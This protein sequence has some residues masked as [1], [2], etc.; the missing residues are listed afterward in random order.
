M[1][2]HPSNNP[3]PRETFDELMSSMNEYNRSDRVQACGI[4]GSI[5][6]RSN[7]RIQ[8]QEQVK[9]PTQSSIAADQ[10]R[11]FSSEIN[12]ESRSQKSTKIAKLL[13]RGRKTSA[14]GIADDQ[15][16]PH[17]KQ[18]WD[19]TVYRVIS[20]S[21]A[22]DKLD[23]FSSSI[24]MVECERSIARLQREL[25]LA[26]QKSV[27]RP[28]MKIEASCNGRDI[29]S[30]ASRLATSF[31]VP[32]LRLPSC[33]PSLTEKTYPADQKKWTSE[34]CAASITSA[35]DVSISKGIP[36]HSGI[37]ALLTKL[38]MAINFRELVKL[39]HHELVSASESD[40]VQVHFINP[41]LNLS[42]LDTDAFQR[43]FDLWS[44]NYPE[45][46][47]PNM[48]SQQAARQCITIRIN[49]DPIKGS[50][51]YIPIT[52]PSNGASSMWK[53]F[54]V[55]DLFRGNEKHWTQA[56]ESRVKFIIE[57]CS[58]MLMQ[59]YKAIRMDYEKRHA[60][61]MSEATKTLHSQ[62]KPDALC[63]QAAMFAC[64]LTN[65]QAARVLLAS[66]NGKT[67]IVF[68]PTSG[69]QKNQTVLSDEAVK[70]VEGDLPSVF[71][72]VIKTAK[73]I[74]VADTRRDARFASVTAGIADHKCGKMRPISGSVVVRPSLAQPFSARPN[75]APDRTVPEHSRPSP[76][77]AHPDTGIKFAANGLLPQP[78]ASGSAATGDGGA[79]RSA[80]YRGVGAQVTHSRLPRHTGLVYS[81]GQEKASEAAEV[82]EED[83]L[84]EITSGAQSEPVGPTD[85][86]GWDVPPNVIL[87]PVMDD[88][89]QEESGRGE[90][91]REVSV[92][93][94][95]E[96]INKRSGP[97]EESDHAELTALCG[98][99]YRCLVNVGKMEV[100][101]DSLAC[102]CRL[103]A[104]S[105]VQ[106]IVSSAL[107][108]L[109][110]STR[111][112]LAAF[113]IPVEG[114][115]VLQSEGADPRHEVLKYI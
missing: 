9:G 104:S 99:L 57:L 77:C 82:D 111:S 81:E 50:A 5:T 83:V 92:R 65:A 26:G 103:L 113:Y 75:T 23:R 70:S 100:L 25:E 27:H 54:G 86:K 60:I 11:A 1:R 40:R 28:A 61:L 20:N 30:S 31:S 109:R 19:G 71:T 22:A 49:E 89:F 84:D 114:R 85:A 47:L 51:L 96:V 102:D 63:Q 80:R 6:E 46:T 73:G 32:P 17:N 3:V 95:L 21:G 106:N 15:T 72:T 4:S 76:Q 59:R 33:V 87:L 7:S 97:F 16:A 58:P 74:S 69:K 8:K 24:S 41:V 56:D 10:D 34:T 44:T 53:I 2:L 42:K 36:D 115:R 101:Q 13:Y 105:S 55:V 35:S 18:A 43:K 91:D 93:G 64:R 39:V 37:I 68:E 62:D 110:A 38:S 12:G 67:A 29:D 107:D 98:T 78:P 90:S 112:D 52:I 45:S 79:L 88:S 48:H 108:K 94:V 14:H 66:D